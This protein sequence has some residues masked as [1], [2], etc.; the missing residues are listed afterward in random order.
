MY[1]HIYIYFYA[2]KLKFKI[3]KK[4]SFKA[5]FQQVRIRMM[6]IILTQLKLQKLIDLLIY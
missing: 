6:Y 1:I 3:L 5:K 2:E 4:N